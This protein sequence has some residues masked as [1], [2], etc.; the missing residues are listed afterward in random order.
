MGKKSNEKN[1]KYTVI[2]IK[3]LQKSNSFKAHS[4]L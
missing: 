2:E 4:Q 1:L 3:L